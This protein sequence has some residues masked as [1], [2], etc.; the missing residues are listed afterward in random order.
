MGRLGHAVDGGG[1]VLRR[2]ADRV[3]AAFQGER[4]GTLGEGDE[5]LYVP[6][7]GIE[8]VEHEDVVQEEAGPEEFE[9]AGIGGAVAVESV[10]AIP[11]AAT[12]VVKDD[13]EGLLSGGRVRFDEFRG[14]GA[15]RVPEFVELRFLEV[16]ET[17]RRVLHFDF[18][19]IAKGGKPRSRV[20]R[21][22]REKSEEACDR[23]DEESA[24]ESH[25]DL[26]GKPKSKPLILLEQSFGGKL[27]VG[28]A[29]SRGD[30][31]FRPRG[32]MRPAET[33]ESVRLASPS[34]A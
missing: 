30:A 12:R 11:E 5:E 13:L 32:S 9:R 7:G 20:G 24:R 4:E 29:Q 21:S 16:L 19:V 6:G 3:G 18:G 14:H 10:P 34:D 28:G 25:D 8:H 17:L 27:R 2:E 22:G 31:S 1:D 26:Q 15:F 23:R 33:S